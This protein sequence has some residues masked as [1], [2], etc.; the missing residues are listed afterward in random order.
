M[1]GTLRDLSVPHRHLRLPE[2]LDVA[3]CVRFRC[4]RTRLP[5]SLRARNRKCTVAQQSSVLA[6]HCSGHAGQQRFSLPRCLHFN[7][8][9]TACTRLCNRPTRVQCRRTI[10]EKKVSLE[11]NNELAHRGQARNLVH[12]DRNRT[13]VTRLGPDRETVS[14]DAAADRLEIARLSP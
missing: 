5:L 6:L 4:Y 2:A 11:C 3:V 12:L 1:R 8:Y 13:A 10:A 14:D 9:C 7:L